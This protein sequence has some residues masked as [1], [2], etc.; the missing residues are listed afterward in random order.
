MQRLNKRVIKKR[1]IDYKKRA[2][3]RDAIHPSNNVSFFHPR[4]SL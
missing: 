4:K 1:T 2:H 3:V